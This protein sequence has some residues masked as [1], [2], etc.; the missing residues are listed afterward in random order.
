MAHRC[1]SIGIS[2]SIENLRLLSDRWLIY[3]FSIIHH[4]KVR[5]YIVRNTAAIFVANNYNNII[6]L[7]KCHLLQN[8]IEMYMKISIWI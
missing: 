5:M 2:E 3:C 1:Y 7:L 4:S 8:Y 6:K